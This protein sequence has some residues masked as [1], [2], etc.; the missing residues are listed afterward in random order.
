MIIIPLIRL[1]RK[2]LRSRKADQRAAGD[3]RHTH[4]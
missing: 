1:I 2:W 4:S 3:T